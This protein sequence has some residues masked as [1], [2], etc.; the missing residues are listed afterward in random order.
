MI[1]ISN[2]NVPNWKT[3]NVKSQIPESLKKLDKLAHNMWWS[4]NQDAKDLFDKM[5]NNT[6]TYLTDYNLG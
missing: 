5:V 1:E 4:W 6:K 2:A 3:I